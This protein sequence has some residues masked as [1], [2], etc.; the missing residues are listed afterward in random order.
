MILRKTKGR[1]FKG[2]TKEKLF[3]EEVNNDLNLVPKEEKHKLK[4]KQA[5]QL[6]QLSGNE[7]KTVKPQ[8]SHDKLVIMQAINYKKQGYTDIKVNHIN[9][10]L[11]QPVKVGD[12]T[13]DLS[14]VF[15]SKIT[16]CEVE[17]N[18]SINDSYTVRKWK[19]FDKSGYKFHLIIPNNAFNMAKQIAK[20]NGITVDKF[21]CSKNY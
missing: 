20:S 6:S 5:P 19:E 2:K 7:V 18:D 3:M 9:Y 15:N 1:K 17:T 16:I 13:P 10:L 14:A 11:G 12:Y 21:W 4:I 8:T